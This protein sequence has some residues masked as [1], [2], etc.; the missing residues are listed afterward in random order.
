MTSNIS[1]ETINKLELYEGLKNDAKTIKTRIDELK[2]E[3]TPVV[4]AEG[5]I[6]TPSG[7]FTIQQRPTWRYSETVKNYEDHLKELKAEEIAKGL[8]EK[9]E[10]PTLYYKANE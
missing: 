5:G 2:A 10:T 8:A 3:L 9:V 1:K 7:K 6:E 4:E